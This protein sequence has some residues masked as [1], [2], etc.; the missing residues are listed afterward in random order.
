[1]LFYNSVLWFALGNRNISFPKITSIIITIYQLPFAT[2]MK[3]YIKLISKILVATFHFPSIFRHLMCF[4]K[5][6]K[7]AQ[8]V[9]IAV[10]YKNSLMIF[11]ESAAITFQ[12]SSLSI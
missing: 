1:M 2:N 3:S 11:V 7:K 9:H 10:V 4:R 5:Q 8:G 6:T 12:A